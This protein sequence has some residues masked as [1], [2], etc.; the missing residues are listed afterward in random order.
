MFA[1]VRLLLSYF[2][3]HGVINIISCVDLSCVDLSCVINILHDDLHY[4][5]K[6]QLIKLQS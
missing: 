6:K 2:D 1:Y 3:L 5:F 4:V